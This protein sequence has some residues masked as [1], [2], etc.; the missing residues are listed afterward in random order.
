[1]FSC[2]FC[3]IF[4]STF[5]NNTSG[6]SLRRW[7]WRDQTTAHDI[8]IEQLWS[9]NDFLWII[10]APGQNE[11]VVTFFYSRP[12]VKMRQNWRVI[13]ILYSFERATFLLRAVQWQC[14]NHGTIIRTEITCNKI[15]CYMRDSACRWFIVK[16]PKIFWSYVK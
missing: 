3:G 10:F 7:A 5:I 8:P 14:Q 16:K 2:E 12:K 9:L 15:P 11:H 1:M 13:S 4:K 6:D